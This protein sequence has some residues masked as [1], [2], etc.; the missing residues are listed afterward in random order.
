MLKFINKI[1][2]Y[3]KTVLILSLL[4]TVLFFKVMKDNSRMETDLDEYM[5]HNYC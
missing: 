4:I 3:P 2:K 5:L 1:N